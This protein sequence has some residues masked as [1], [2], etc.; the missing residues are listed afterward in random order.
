MFKKNIILGLS[1]FVLIGCGSGGSNSE[2]ENI[3]KNPPI[4]EDKDINITQNPQVVPLGNN[5]TLHLKINLNS[6]ANNL[7]LV[8]SNKD[9]NS[10]SSVNINHN[11]KVIES[12][13]KK[14]YNSIKISKHRILHAPDYILKFNHDAIKKLKPNSGKRENIIQ[15]PRKNLTEGTTHTFYLDAEGSV[16]TNATLRRVHSNI[17]TAFGQKTLNVWVSN[18]SFG[19]GCAKATCVTQEMVDKLADKF[20]KEGE[21]NDIYDWVANIYGEEWGADAHNKYINLIPKSDT[22]DIL[23]TDIDDDNNSKGG[24]IGYFWSK[25]NYTQ[26]TY[27]GSNERIMFYADSVMFANTEENGF[28]QKELYA[29]L[30]HEFQHMIHFYQKYVKNNIESEDWLNE[31]MA[32]ATEDLIATKIKHI[33]D[34]GVDYTDGSAGE[35]N[36]EKG[37]IPLFNKYNTITI[38]NWNNVSKDYAKAYS[39]GAFLIRNYGGAEL[40]HNMMHNNYGN[41]QAV[42]S[43]IKTTVDKDVT[44]AQLLQEWGEAIMLSDHD[45]LDT[46]T[47]KYNIGD[48]MISDYNGIDYKMGSINFFNYNPQPTIKTTVNKINPHANCYYKI[49]ENINSNSVNLN[50]TL[51]ANTQAVLIAK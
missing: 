2:Y 36:N 8:L 18:D 33:G 45:D 43:A 25:D 16:T 46:D 47:P 42:I 32:V 31:M 49:G 10:R 4:T 38:T 30:A 44:F 13:N 48:F 15:A 51:D 23:L 24:V 6:S 17:N 3:Y 14:N 26:E 21:N 37:R 28:W 34:R 22:I 35:A 7:Y 19:N 40:L 27:T 29:T 39:F 1:I 5:K 50:I 20:L 9:K 11:A 41:E 12:K